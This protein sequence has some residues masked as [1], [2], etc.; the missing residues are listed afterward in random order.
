MTAESL[1]PYTRVFSITCA[2]VFPSVIQ[3]I[4]ERRRRVTTVNALTQ[5]SLRDTAG[6]KGRILYPEKRKFILPG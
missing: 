5:Q 4:V 3:G 1:R 6:I 2:P